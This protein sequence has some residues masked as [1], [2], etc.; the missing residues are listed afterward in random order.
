VRIAQGKQNGIGE[1]YIDRIDVW[2]V[3]VVP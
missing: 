1:T 2:G 3:N